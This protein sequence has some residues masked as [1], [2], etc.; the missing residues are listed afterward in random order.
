MTFDE[1]RVLS[2]KATSGTINDAFFW[3]ESVDWPDSAF[4]AACVN[5]VRQLLAVAGPKVTM[6]VLDPPEPIK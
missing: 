5:Y 6:Q 2:E 4:A 3:G 1:L